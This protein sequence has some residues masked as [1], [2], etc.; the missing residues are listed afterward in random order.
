MPRFVVLFHEMPRRADRP[1][2]WDFMLE[3]GDVLRTWALE[4]EPDAV[5]E[6]AAQRLAD[7]RLAYLEFEGPVSGDRGQVTR[8]DTGEYLIAAKSAREIEI[9]LKGR[10]LHCQVELTQSGEDQPWRFRIVRRLTRSTSD[11]DR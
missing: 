3:T 10:R 4:T 1:S 11:L 5:E 6:Q 2:H 8:W 9:E 7:H